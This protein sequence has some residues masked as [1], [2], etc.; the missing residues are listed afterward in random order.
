MFEE[1]QKVVKELDTAHTALVTAAE[2]T[3][4]AVKP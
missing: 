1:S 4:R 3:H 2:A